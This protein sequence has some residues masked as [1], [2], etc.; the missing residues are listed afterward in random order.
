MILRRRLLQRRCADTAQ[1]KKSVSED[2][3]DSIGF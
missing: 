3:N 2:F 1:P